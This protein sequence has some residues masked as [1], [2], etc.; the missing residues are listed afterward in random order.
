[1]ISV[2]HKTDTA[3]KA[4][5][6]GWVKA[7]SEAVQRLLANDLPKKD[8]IAVARAAAVMAAKKTFELIP[9]CHPIPLDVVEID[10]KVE[11]ELIKVTACVEAV[12]KTGVEMEALTAVSTAAL[13]I[14]DMLKPVCKGLEIGGIKLVSK[15]GGRS[16]RKQE[17]L[18]DDFKAVLLI[19][20]DGVFDGTRKD[21][22]TPLVR[23]CLAEF[24][25]T[26]DSVVIP[27][28]FS[29]VRQEL[30][31]LCEQGYSL[32][33]TAGGTGLGEQDATVEA[34][35]KV[36]EREIPGI[37]EA[38]RAYGQ[39]RTPYAMLSRGLAGQKGKTII[40]NL[41]GSSK[42]VEESLHALF[43]GVLHVFKMIY[44]VK[45]RKGEGVAV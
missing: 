34:T 7:S 41:P 26:I 20:S 32:V 23:K 25:V 3:R 43:P 13:T 45:A 18:P 4:V 28:E 44:G 11:P 36:I 24:G 21:K 31:R 39:R 29:R 8:V 12:W 15:K 10:F 9:Y 30:E 33:L 5:A 2:V 22:V 27:G 40:I 16:S 19:T 1:M 14:Y 6:E 37:M 42:G 38:C 35:S 17:W